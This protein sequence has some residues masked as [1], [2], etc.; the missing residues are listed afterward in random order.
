M[1][2]N[3]MIVAE[4]VKMLVSTVR[5]TVPPVQLGCFSK[6]SLGLLGITVSVKMSL[7]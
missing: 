6:C 4:G 3:Y 5:R 1:N 7:Y 2:A